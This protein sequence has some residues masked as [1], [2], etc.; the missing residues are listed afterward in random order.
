MSPSC[1]HATDIKQHQKPGGIILQ[2]VCLSV[3]LQPLSAKQPIGTHHGMTSH[4]PHLHNTEPTVAPDTKKK[5]KHRRKMWKRHFLLRLRSIW[6][7]TASAN[8]WLTDSNLTSNSEVRARNTL[9]F[10]STLHFVLPHR[11]WKSEYNQNYF[12]SK[13]LQTTAL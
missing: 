6:T 12:Q 1:H 7:A 9:G 11:P 3:S 10:S 4:I 13:F 2:C 8:F 5:K